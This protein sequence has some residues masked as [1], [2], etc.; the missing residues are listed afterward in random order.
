MAS[1]QDLKRTHLLVRKVVQLGEETYLYSFVGVG[2]VFSVGLLHMW[3]EDILYKIYSFCKWHN[4]Y[5]FTKKK[6]T[7]NALCIH[8]IT[9]RMVFI[10]C[11]LCTLLN[12]QELGLCMNKDILSL[13]FSTKSE[14]C[15]MHDLPLLTSLVHLYLKWSVHSLNCSCKQVYLEWA[16]E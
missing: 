4:M 8:K 7:L 16:Y 14:A 2:K 11:F 9:E 13:I 5:H 1:I 12:K 3:N 10:P 15:D 6:K